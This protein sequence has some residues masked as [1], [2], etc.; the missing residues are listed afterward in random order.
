MASVLPPP[1]YGVAELLTPLMRKRVLDKND[2]LNAIQDG[3]Y[4][5][6]NTSVPKNY[7]GYN[8]L[9]IQQSGLSGNDV[10]KYQLAMSYNDNKCGFRVCSG[11]WKSWVEL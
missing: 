4:S 7:F 8:S 5:Y 11:T 2:D 6:H 1:E 3:I 9:L 10:Y